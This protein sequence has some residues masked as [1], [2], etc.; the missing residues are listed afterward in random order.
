M[1]LSDIFKESHF[2]LTDAEFET[3]F[4]N[5]GIDPSEFTHVAHLRLAWLH[6]SKHGLRQAQQNIQDQIK[7]FVNHVGAADKY[8]TTLTVAAV[9]IVHAF[10]QKTKTEEFTDF[11]SEFPELALNF[12]SLL[13]THYSPK[14]LFSDEAKEEF[15]KADRLAFDQEYGPIL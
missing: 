10:K 7:T 14:R 6:I 9:N 4:K 2:T 13:F 1:S 12:K 11:I 8:H 15:I 3:S 5:C